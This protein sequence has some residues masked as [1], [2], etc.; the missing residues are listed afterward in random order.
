MKEP[1]EW[2][3]RAYGHFSHQS[4]NEAVDRTRNILT[5]WAKK[6]ST[7]TYG[8]LIA[9]LQMLDWPEGPYTHHGSQVGKLLGDASVAE[10]I[11]DRPLLSALV[12]SR[13]GGGPGEGFYPLCEE[14]LGDVIGSSEDAKMRVWSREVA[15]CLVYWNAGGA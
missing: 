10:W 6:G 1:P 3:R 5:G 7:G 4:W 9:E 12:I 8:E 15:R 14:L 2:Y 13:E 11:E